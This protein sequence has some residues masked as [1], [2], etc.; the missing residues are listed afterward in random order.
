LEREGATTV[1]VR[2][3]HLEYALPVYYIISPSEASS[4]LAR[5]DGVRYGLRRPGDDVVAM[6]SRTLR[7]G[8]GDEVKR[9]I[10]LGT[11]ALSTG[12]YEAFYLKAQK[13]RTLIRRDFEQAFERADV[14][15]TPVSPSVP[16]RLG[17]RVDDQLQM[18]LTDI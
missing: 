17:E 7:D 8:F 9:R 6:F 11:Y 12:Y 4:N 16:F 1:E 2:M 18:Y 3:P 14:L 10:M 15:V 5:Y 13:V